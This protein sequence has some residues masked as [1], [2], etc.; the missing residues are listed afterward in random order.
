MAQKE[1]A[2]MAQKEGARMAK[3]N[4]TSSDPRKKQIVAA[5]KQKSGARKVTLVTHDTVTNTFRGHCLN[6]PGAAFYEV[7]AEECGL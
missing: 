2:R 7:T 5:L 6:G 3:K 4:V 1:G